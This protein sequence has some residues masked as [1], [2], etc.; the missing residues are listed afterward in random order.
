MMRPILSAF[1]TSALLA[2]PAAHAVE[3]DYFNI[4]N[5][6]NSQLDF[7]TWSMGMG[8]QSRTAT[9][10]ISSSN[11]NNGYTNPPP[12]KSPPAVHEN[13]DV[14]VLSRYANPGYFFYL[15]RDGNN[16]GNA[17][18]SFSLEH[19]DTLSGNNWE[20]LNH[21]I[22]DSHN[23]NGQFKAC[24]NGKNSGLR[25]TLSSTQLE[26]VRAGPYRAKLRMEGT[27]GS[28]QSATDADNFRAD[29]VVSDIVRASGL[30]DIAFGIHTPGSDQVG[31][32]T[33]CVYS[34]NDTAGYNVSISS[35]NQDAGG[36]FFL[37]SPDDTIPYDV[38]FKDSTVAGF[39]TP[40]GLGAIP[41]NGNNRASDCG[42]SNNAKLSVSVSD[43]DIVP[44]ETG[45]YSDTLTLL[46][47][48][49]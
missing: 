42:G 29:I 40:V 20:T 17:R 19:I 33:F 48:P 22:F 43:S 24:K 38:Y 32:R 7:G 12:V 2:S 9:F 16:T 25:I 8:S 18:F 11:Y 4:Y 34:N 6:P 47:A 27:G 13:Y 41:G 26:N 37:K 1:L 44:S 39:G 15:D 31:E 36:N 5:V 49:L 23:H 30:S 35:S 28:S 46:I 14:R 3:A 10:C 45:N 21:N